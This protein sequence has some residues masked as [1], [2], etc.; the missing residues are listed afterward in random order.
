MRE[1]L[2]LCSENKVAVTA[3]LI[4]VFVFAYA[5]KW[6]SHDAAQIS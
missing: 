4:F 2:Y 5:K 6:F 3:W 1:N